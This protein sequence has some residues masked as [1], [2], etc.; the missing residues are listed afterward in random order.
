MAENLGLL[1]A[2][3]SK[4]P[5]YCLLLQII[6]PFSWVSRDLEPGG[7]AKR[8]ARSIEANSAKA[9]FSARALSP[10]LVRAALL[11]P[12]PTQATH[13]QDKH[14]SAGTQPPLTCTTTIT[15]MAKPLESWTCDELCAF[16][17][18]RG[19]QSTAPKFKECNITGEK[20]E[21]GGGGGVAA[22]GSC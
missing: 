16:L 11:F 7:R 17:W 19:L 14:I 6:V 13:R 21:A 15:I 3:C 4:P 12:S 20:Q 9:A 22:L 2:F 5:G 10:K 8:P 1:H 18:S